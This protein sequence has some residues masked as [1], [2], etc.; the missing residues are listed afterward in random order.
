[1]TV[2]GKFWS[3]QT[4]IAAISAATL[5][6]SGCA[7]SNALNEEDGAAADSSDTV[8][9][10]VL[11]S[12]SG[13]MAISE[14]SLRD[15]ELMAIEE[16]NEA[17]GVLGKQIEPIV[18]DGASD[19]PTF[20]EKA[21][22]LLQKD[23]VAAVFG[24]WTSASRKAM[25]P[26]FE[27]N[28]G[29]LW[30]PVQYEG[31]ESSPNIFYTGATTNQQIV[32]SVTWL[33]ENKGK[34]FFL[35]GSD[36]VFPRT[37][38]KEIKAQLEAEGG[39]LVGEEYT[40]LGHTDYG[41]LI[42]KIKAEKP[43]VIYNTLNG[44]SNVAFFKQL[45]DAGI[46]ADDV[47]V[48]SVSIAEEEIR[49]IGTDILT[50]HYAAWNY[51]QTTDTPENEKFVAAYKE[52]YG[53]DRVTG[54]SIEAAY[55]AVYLWAAA[56]EK[57]GSFDVDAVKEAA[58]GIEFNA[59]GGKVTIDGDNQHTYKTVRVGEIQADG[60]FKEVWNSGEPVKPDPYLETYPWA[61]GL[62]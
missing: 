3:K 10:G 62:N 35:I 22:K 51:F 36:Y 55:M 18:E 17:G 39:T 20:A 34:S 13:T 47:T 59:P 37:A 45:K 15:A 53:D 33:L 27:Q 43:E 48:L 19:W 25:L 38:N 58:G 6:L 41:T 8:K 52:A 21:K 7:A 54:D 16:I 60:Q 23:E 32:P 46:T 14:V 29:L 1:M 49:G 11:H 28:N 12:L 61:E 9:V 4:I 2:L 31:M 50:G 56:A 40:P 57:A 44:D 24:G 5:A 30:Y 26:V 42:S